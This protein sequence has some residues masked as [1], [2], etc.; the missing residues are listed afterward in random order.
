MRSWVQIPSGHVTAER[1]VA[2]MISSVKKAVA[3]DPWG[4]L[5]RH[6][7]P[8]QQAPGR[9]PSS[10]HSVEGLERWLRAESDS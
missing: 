1:S 6:F 4:S 3:L 8:E 9:V 7:L 5:A 10:K 2:P